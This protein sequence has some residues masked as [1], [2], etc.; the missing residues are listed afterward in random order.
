MNRNSAIKYRGVSIHSIRPSPHAPASPI[1]SEKFVRLRWTPAAWFIHCHG[2]FTF[3]PAIDDGTDQAL[4]G[5]HFVGAGEQGCA[6]S[7]RVQQEAGINQ[8]E[9]YLTSRPLTLK[10]ISLM[11]A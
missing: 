5:F 10:E 11:L 2:F 4:G 1:Y 8:R 9:G 7:D 3:L 6:T